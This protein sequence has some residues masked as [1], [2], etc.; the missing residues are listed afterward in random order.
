MKQ[1]ATTSPALARPDRFLA[2][3][4]SPDRSQ[5]RPTGAWLSLPRRWSTETRKAFLGCLQD[6]LSGGGRR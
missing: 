1:L 6:A 4:V 2:R 3:L 5:S